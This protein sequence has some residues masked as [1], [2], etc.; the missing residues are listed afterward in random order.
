[1]PRRVVVFALL[2][3][4]AAAVCVRLGF[5]QLSRLSQRKRVNATV[6]ARLSKSVAPIAALPADSS[7]RLRRATV[8]GTPDYDHQIVL[9]AR[10]FEGSP[11]VWLVTPVKIAGTDSAVLVNRG[12]VYAPD[13]M[14]VDL[15][16]WRERDST[17]SGYAELMPPP[18][19][20]GLEAVLRPRG[21]VL[22]ALDQTAVASVLPYSVSP[23]Y[24]VATAPDSATPVRERVARLG[25]PALDEGPHLGY[26]LQ[27]FSFAVVALVGAGAVVRKSRSEGASVVRPRTLDSP[28]GARSP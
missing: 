5:W 24:L 13:G 7:S 25:T 14:S 11:G 9:A 21:R 15:S 3:V 4:V 10:S 2:A 17:F 26:A 18:S 19:A 12:W 28:T 8:R 16:R 23:L 22:R 6:S 27:W 20:N 1:M